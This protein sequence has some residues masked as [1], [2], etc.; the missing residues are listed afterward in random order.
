MS[1][2]SSRSAVGT[3]VGGIH[4]PEEKEWAADS[5]IEVL[6]LPGE[7]RVSLLQHLGATCEATVKPRQEVRAGD[8]IGRS[9][10]FVTAPVHASIAG[11]VQREMVATLPNGRHV[12]VIP[13]K[14]AAE[15][16]LRGG[17]LLADIFGGPWPLDEVDRCEPGEIVRA[18]REGG[19]VGLGGAAFPT[20]VKLV[21]NEKFPI[22]TVIM[23][24]CECEPYL[25]A[26][27]RV[28]LEFPEPIVV[29]TLLAQRA[30]GAQ[31]ALVCIEDNKLRAI[32]SLRRAAKGTSVE[33]V[34]LRTKYPQG[35]ERQLVAA[36][37]GRI[38]PGG[39]L[40][41]QVG[42][43]VV[44]VAT[45]AAL[46]RSALR[47]KPL[48]HR[49]VTV[50]GA[51]IKHPKNLLTPLG[52]TYGELIRY[53]GGVTEDAARVV[54]G[55][56]MMGFTLSAADEKSELIPTPVTKG[57][58]GIT[59]LTDRDVRR[60]GQTACIR[61]GRCVEVC[62]MRLVPTRLALAARAQHRGVLERYH[63]GACI[64]CGCCA[65]TC[66]ASIPLV[67]LIRVGKVIIQN[68]R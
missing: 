45:A 5:P 54:A 43:V 51:G 22:D 56:P 12:P 65:F 33:V 14:A 53:C 27:Y 62:P 47:G 21:R 10:A 32:E 24:G 23:N 8:V 29:G 17:A 28:M 49:V 60:A 30:V 58:S 68:H 15:Q 16:E 46:A 26:D 63:I 2:F 31:R 25:T 7:V 38:V 6:P 18:A 52:T 67:Q 34:V 40:P 42:V 1:L 44:N 39:G 37:T 59:V 20:H 66:P 13:I 19:L 11:T 55:G 36:A 57:T 9:E 50:S 64:E 61:C 3:F 4:P 35:G 41:F 48:T